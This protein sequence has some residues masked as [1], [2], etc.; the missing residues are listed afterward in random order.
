[1]QFR[2]SGERL[3]LTLMRSPSGDL[4]YGEFNSELLVVAESDTEDRLAGQVV[5]NCDD[6]DAAFEELEKRYLAGEAANHARTWS[7]IARIYAEC[8][9]H[10]FPASTRDPIFVD[11]RPLVAIDA[12][13]MAASVRAVLDLTPDVSI[14]AEAVHRLSALGAVVAHGLKGTTQEGFVGEW[15]MISLFT[16]KAT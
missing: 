2:K 11:H 8:N 5:F 13:E 16:V 9:R 3:A 7:V 12:V 10:K 6:I 4:R 15:Q 14:Y 1:V